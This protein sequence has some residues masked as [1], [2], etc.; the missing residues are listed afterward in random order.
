M[1]RRGRLNDKLSNQRRRRLR[2]VARPLVWQQIKVNLSGSE[3]GSIEFGGIEC[4]SSW[5]WRSSS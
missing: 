4:G 1:E 5:A 3:C 2:R